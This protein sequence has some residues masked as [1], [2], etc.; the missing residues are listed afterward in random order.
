MLVWRR[1]WWNELEFVAEAANHR[2]IGDASAA[3]GG[4]GLQVSI[5]CQEVGNNLKGRIVLDACAFG[6]AAAPWFVVHEGLPELVSVPTR[7]FKP[8]AARGPSG[9]YPGAGCYYL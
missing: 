9:H 2:G 4:G 7:Q 5:S 3:D 6:P 1:A 8:V